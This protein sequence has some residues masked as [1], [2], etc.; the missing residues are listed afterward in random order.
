MKGRASQE[1]GLERYQSGWD[2]LVKSL[3]GPPALQLPCGALWASFAAWPPCPLA[4]APQSVL[5][6]AP[7]ASPPSPPSSLVVPL[8]GPLHLS[9]GI[10][11]ADQLLQASSAFN[12][13]ERGVKE[14]TEMLSSSQAC[15]FSSPKPLLHELGAGVEF[16]FGGGFTKG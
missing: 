13:K 16:M 11:D 15:R 7:P 1:P 8:P 9:P 3:E 5:G 6:R 12:L 2:A 14:R 10:P 4:W